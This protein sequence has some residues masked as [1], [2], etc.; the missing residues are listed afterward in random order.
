VG[1]PT[2]LIIRELTGPKNRLTLQGRAL[3][4]R[5][6]GFEGTMRAELAWYP[7]NPTATVQVMGPEEGTSSINGMWKDRFIRTSTDLGLPVLGQTGI[8][9][10]NGSLVADVADLV[11]IVDGFR[12]RGQLLEL[13]W[14]ELTRH[15]I[16]TKFRHTWHRRED[17]EWEIDF[18]W[19]SQGESSMPTGFKPTLAIVDQVNEA[20]AGVDDLR[21]RIAGLKD[22]YASVAS[23]MGIVDDAMVTIQ[24]AASALSG[25]AQQLGKAALLPLDA[26]RSIASIYETLR[27]QADRIIQA[28]VS[29][30]ARLQRVVDDIADITHEQALDSNNRVLR[31]RMSARAL[32][33]LAALK[34]QEA[35]AQTQKQT[36]P[37][38]VFTST[39]NTNLRDVSRIYYGVSW[40]WRRIAEYNGL[41]SS[42]LPAGLTI[43]VPKIDGVTV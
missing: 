36:A 18:S 35:L 33:A 6:I 23:V 43:I 13:V 39:Q 25:A 32:R 1:S 34:E 26:I 11:K 3:P 15:G 4:Y 31:I 27:T 2:S 8:A 12:R 14:D 42:K 5:P 28:F 22:S 16:M 10:Y 37:L 29:L 17:V 41:R 40:E 30:P 19:T 20:L 24:E 38:A 9:R 7:G 21:E